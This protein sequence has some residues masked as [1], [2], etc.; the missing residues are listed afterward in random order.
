MELNFYSKKLEVK[1]GKIF[2]FKNSTISCY[3]VPS[4]SK[5]TDFIFVDSFS[6]NFILGRVSQRQKKIKKNIF[7]F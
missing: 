6:K 1:K 4:A 7:I 5:G 2:K 3:L